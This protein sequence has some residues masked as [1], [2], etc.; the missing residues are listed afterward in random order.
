MWP[1]IVEH[2]DILIGLLSMWL[3]SNAVSALPTPQPGG[4]AFYVWFFKF[5][6]PI[7]AGIPRLLAIFWPNTLSALTGQAVK[8]NPTSNPP[9]ATPGS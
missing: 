9:P 2:K 8:Q 5:T 7:G 3:I 6:Q 1:F 4:S